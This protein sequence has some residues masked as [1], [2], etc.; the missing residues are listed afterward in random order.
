V[1]ITKAVR[2]PFLKHDYV[3][4]KVVHESRQETFPDW[5]RF[6]AIFGPKGTDGLV[7]FKMDE[8]GERR[9]CRLVAPGRV[10]P[11]A[12]GSFELV[13][14]TRGETVP[15]AMNPGSAPPP[16]LR[17]LVRGFEADHFVLQVYGAEA[18]LPPFP[19]AS[20]MTRLPGLGADERAIVVPWE[21][22]RQFT[23]KAMSGAFAWSLAARDAQGALIAHT[24]IE[25]FRTRLEE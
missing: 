13:W 21:A 3:L 24:N 23:P 16:A 15:I 4:L 19:V 18:T 8:D 10:R 20:A 6:D 7:V 25:S 11:P 22:L 14:P 12:G 5:K 17:F 1:G 9:I 2:T